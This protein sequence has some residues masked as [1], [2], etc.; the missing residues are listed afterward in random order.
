MAGVRPRVWLRYVDDVFAVWS[1][2][3]QQLR[4]F[5]EHLNH[6]HTNIQFTTEEID[7]K[8]A[9][10]DVLVERYGSGVRSSVFCK[11]THTDG[12]VHQFPVP[13]SLENPDR[14]HPMP[15][16]PSTTGS[17]IQPPSIRREDT[18]RTSSRPTASPDWLFPRCWT[19]P[20]VIHHRVEPRTRR[21]GR[22]CF[23]ST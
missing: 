7:G 16:T 2:S 3:E 12:S 8:I 4:Q 23:F 6:Q 10:L 14:D 21:R 20:D 19:E 11:K 22:C 18:S 1:G 9:F 15:Q 17:A 13:P 5:H